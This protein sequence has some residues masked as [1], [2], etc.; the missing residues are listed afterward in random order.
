LNAVQ[1][2]PNVTVA[3]VVERDGRFL[4]VE[5]AI[6]KRHVLNQPAGHLEQGESLSGAVRREVLEET[7]WT[8]EPDGLVGVYLLR[9][10]TEGVTYLRFCFSTRLIAHDPQRPLDP[11]IERTRWLTVDELRRESGRHRST[12]VLRS[13]EDYLAGQR[14]PLELLRD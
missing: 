12:L 11:E 4:F 9:S 2:K 8:V 3:A 7:G 6:G 14:Y 1:W 5:E 10:E 13:V